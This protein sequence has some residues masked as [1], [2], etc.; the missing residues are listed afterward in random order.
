[1]PDSRSL[2]VIGTFSAKDILSMHSP[3]MA[4]TF[5]TIQPALVQ[6]NAN[7]INIPTTG[8]YGTLGHLVLT[9]GRTAYQALSLGNVNH[10]PPAAPPA[11]S[12][13]PQNST[14]VQIS[15]A[16]R[17]FDDT[18]RG[19]KLYHTVEAVLKQQLLTY[20]DDKYFKVHKNRNTG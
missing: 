7:A 6:L 11:A 3:N 10:P 4:P 17:T 5:E 8:G 15:E 1:M 20:I 16:R 13:F 18:V 12:T 14:G 2:E 9:I 19:F